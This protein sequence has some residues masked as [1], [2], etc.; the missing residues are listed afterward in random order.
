MLACAGA[1]PGGRR[2]R[3]RRYAAVVA[4]GRPG[5]FGDRPPSF[6]FAL[7]RSSEALNSYVELSSR[8]PRGRRVDAR[9][10]EK[11]RQNNEHI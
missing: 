8:R 2:R 1:M 3:R 4:A 6:S 7:L 5:F 9:G 11:L 10:R